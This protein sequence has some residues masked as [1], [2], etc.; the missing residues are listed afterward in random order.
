MDTKSAST[1]S[2][3]EAHDRATMW[4]RS[5]K[6]AYHQRRAS[7][8]HRRW[9]RYCIAKAREFNTIARIADEDH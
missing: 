4:E 9:T 2:W 3:E 7:L 6:D 8:D 1:L 5:A